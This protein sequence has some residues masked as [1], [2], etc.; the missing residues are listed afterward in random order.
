L[1]VDDSRNRRKAAV[2][3]LGTHERKAELRELS[4]PKDFDWKVS[5]KHLQ[6]IKTICLDAPTDQEKMACA[7]VRV[8]RAAVPFVDFLRQDD[9][10]G[11]WDYVVPLGANP[12]TLRDRGINTRTFANR[13]AQYEVT[14]NIIVR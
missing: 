14:T 11:G 4:K 3:D 5:D 12:Y 6:E 1:S 13:G 9:Y 2:Q 8:F 7:A 10:V